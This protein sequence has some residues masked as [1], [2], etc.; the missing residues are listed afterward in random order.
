LLGGKF[1]V[2]V[3]DR[4]E[5]V[6]LS[7]EGRWIESEGWR[8]EAP[9]SGLTALFSCVPTV[10][11]AVVAAAVGAARAADAV[12]ELLADLLRGFA[13]VNRSARNLGLPTLGVSHG[14]VFGCVTEHGVPMA[15][16]D[17]EFTTGSL[18]AAEAQAFLLGHVH[19]H[20]VWRRE[21]SAG[22]QCIAY[23]GSIG[24]FHYGEEGDKGILIWDVDADGADCT[25]I[26]TPARR[27][28]DIGFDGMPNVEALTAAIGAV[29]IAGAFIRVRWT[30]AEEDD[31]SVDR[32]AILRQLASAAEVKLEGRTVPLQRSRA[33]GIAQA[34]SLADKVMAWAAVNA[35]RA[36]PL[37]DCLN[38]LAGE[39]VEGIV[40]ALMNAPD[41]EVDRAVNPVGDGVDA[42]V[43]VADVAL[44]SC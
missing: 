14:T 1:G 37:L 22:R 10:N 9:P 29:D 12:G 25:L 42:A 44:A 5:Q 8:F 20:Q 43:E 7:A 40:E 32:A 4:I 23:P 18:F 3:A 16:F 35:C 28:L 17:H 13:G 34:H 31:A 21:S 30:V 27:T 6:G 38:G 2:H 19:R 33:S 41:R 39:S 11:K 24:R 36:E 26:H 15:G